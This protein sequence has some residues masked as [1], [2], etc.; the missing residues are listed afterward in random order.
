MVTIRID[1]CAEASLR[2]LVAP[3]IAKAH[4]DSELERRLARMGYGLR[5]T[6]AGRKLVT[7]PHGVELIDLPAV[8]RPRG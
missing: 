6:G 2:A 1:A 8:A 7:L 5:R 3:E 4:D